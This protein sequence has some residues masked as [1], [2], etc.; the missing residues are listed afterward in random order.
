MN[1]CTH[2]D[3]VGSVG[4][5]L[6][7]AVS[8]CRAGVLRARRCGAVGLVSGTLLLRLTGLENSALPLFLILILSLA[9]T[10]HGCGV[11]TQP[12]PH[13]H[14]HTKGVV[15]PAAC[16]SFRGGVAANEAPTSSPG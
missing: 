16:V 8:S 3:A 10:V 11:Q 13:T 2:K 1:T 5:K 12:A 9:L 6:S 14:T 7:V 15:D 4:T